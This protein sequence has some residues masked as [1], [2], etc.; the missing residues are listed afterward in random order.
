MFMCSARFQSLGLAK[1]YL[2]VKSHFVGT[3]L[4]TL[5]IR[6]FEIINDKTSPM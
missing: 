1:S 4:C 2:A 5:N 6:C 3:P